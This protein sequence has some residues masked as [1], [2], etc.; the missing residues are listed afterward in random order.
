MYRGARSDSCP[1]AEFEGEQ[2]QEQRVATALAHSCALLAA[3][4]RADA[5]AKFVPEAQLLRFPGLIQTQQGAAGVTQ[6][7]GGGTQPEWIR[8]RAAKRQ[9][10]LVGLVRASSDQHFVGTL[11]AIM[12]HPGLQRRGFGRRCATAVLK[13]STA[14]F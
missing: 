3:Y 2:N 1:C 8:R 13:P 6:R 14:F 12:V 4:C 9:K 7:G 10:I 5:V 11:D